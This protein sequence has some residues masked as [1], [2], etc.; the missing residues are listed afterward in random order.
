M[1]TSIESVIAAAKKG[2]ALL[3]CILVLGGCASGYVIKLNNGSQI[4]GVSKPRLKD[5]TYYF[6]DA[7]GQEHSVSAG[8]V[9]QI[10]PASM[11]REEEK[12]HRPPQ[13][14]KRKWY[15]LWLA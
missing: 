9:S 4:T 7:K 8:R 1:E 3:A 10:A 15:L 13:P 12:S 11:A 6:K 5:N 14:H 2:L